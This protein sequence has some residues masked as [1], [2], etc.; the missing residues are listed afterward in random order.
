M[1]AEEIKWQIDEDPWLTIVKK[2]KKKKNA[3]NIENFGWKKPLGR[4]K[5]IGI[6]K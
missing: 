2:P 6:K 4:K 5:V 1:K 3:E